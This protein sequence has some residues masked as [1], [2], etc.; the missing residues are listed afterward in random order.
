M[1]NLILKQLIKD[2]GVPARV[3]RFRF[4]ADQGSSQ[5]RHVQVKV[6][7]PAEKNHV[8]VDVGKLSWHIAVTSYSH[9]HQNDLEKMQANQFK[10]Y[11]IQTPKFLTSHKKLRFSQ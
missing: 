11:R 5:V 4:P 1:Y 10:Y 8:G 7:F 2:S 6:V 3:I 9:I